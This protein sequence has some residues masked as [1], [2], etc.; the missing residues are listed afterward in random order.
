M[1]ERVMAS[2]A[3]RLTR[4]GARSARLHWLATQSCSLVLLVASVTTSSCSSGGKAPRPTRTRSIL[5][6]GES[7]LQIARSPKNHGVATTVEL[8]GDLQIGG[9]IRAGQSQ[10]QSATENQSLRRGV[11]SGQNLQPL[12]CVAV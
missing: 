9:L 3:W 12:Q 1:V 5:K 10:D 6:A 11:G 7:V 2:S 4:T 8:V